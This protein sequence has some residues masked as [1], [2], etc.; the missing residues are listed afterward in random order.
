LPLQVLGL[1]LSSNMLA[2]AEEHR[3]EM[4]AEVADRVSFCQADA[5]RFN[6]SPNKFDL[7]YSR[8]AIMHIAEK[9]K[10][11]ANVFVSDCQAK[12]TDK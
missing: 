1:D 8:D 7:M 4:G 11:Y 9:E 10:L 5:T 3:A 2:I 6:F 12:Q